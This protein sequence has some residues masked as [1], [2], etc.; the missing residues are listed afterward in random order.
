MFW[1]EM[2]FQVCSCIGIPIVSVYH[3]YMFVNTQHYFLESEPIGEVDPKFLKSANSD[4][5]ALY[6]NAGDVF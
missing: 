6:I 5:I 3:I 2:R 1:V 4:V